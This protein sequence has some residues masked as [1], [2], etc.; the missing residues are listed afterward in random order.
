MTSTPLESETR[1]A[2]AVGAALLG[3]ADPAGPKKPRKAKRQRTANPLAN[4][5]RFGYI[6]VSGYVL[7]LLAFGIVPTLYAVFLSI[8]KNGV[9]VGIDNFVRVFGDYRFLPAVGH[10]TLYIV[11]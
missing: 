7:L 10:V 11:F 8:T 3:D 1:S 9:F 6:F 5:T 4:E 2:P